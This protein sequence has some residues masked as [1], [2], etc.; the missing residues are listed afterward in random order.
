MGAVDEYEAGL[1]AE[2]QLDAEE[3]AE[4]AGDDGESDDEGEGSGGPDDPARR[5]RFL[6]ATRF[7]PDKV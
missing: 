7:L 3:A 2:A 5:S 6:N 1:E 4:Y